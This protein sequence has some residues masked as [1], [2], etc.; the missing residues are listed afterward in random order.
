MATDNPDLAFKVHSAQGRSCSSPGKSGGTLLSRILLMLSLGRAHP[1]FDMYSNQP[2]LDCRR[3][4]SRAKDRTDWGCT[5]QLN[6]LCMLSWQTLPACEPPVATASLVSF[7]SHLTISI[8]ILIA[9]SVVMAHVYVCVCAR[10]CVRA[11]VRVCVCVCVCVFLG[12][13]NV[14]ATTTKAK[15]RTTPCSY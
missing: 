11:C 3:H 9:L 15:R 14:G 10:A 6:R 12:L 13:Y 8:E 1:L 2:S 7:R 5:R 4:R